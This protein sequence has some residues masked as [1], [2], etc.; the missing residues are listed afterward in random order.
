MPVLIP[1]KKIPQLTAYGINLLGTEMLEISVTN[2]SRRITARDFVLPLDSVLTVTPLGVVGSNSRQLTLGI[3]LVAV[4]GGP[5]STYQ[6]NATGAVAGPANPTGTVGLT[7]VNG[8]ALTYMR[9]DAAPPLSQAIVPSWT[10]THE[11]LNNVK[12]G[13][14]S[15]SGRQVGPTSARLQVEGTNNATSSMSIVRN[16]PSNDGGFLTLGK[17]RGVTPAGVTILVDND[18]YGQLSFAG[19]D[20]VDLISVGARIT[21]QVDGVPAVGS[22]PGRLVLLTTASGAVTPTERFR[23]ISN[24]AWGLGG[25]TYGNAG[26][27]IT[28]VGAGGPP[29]W[30]SKVANPTALVGLA[31]VNGVATTAIRS[32]GA[33]ALDQA[34][35]PTWT[36]QHIFSLSGATNAAILAS[37]AQPQVDW[38]ETDAAANNRRWRIEAQ[39]EQQ[40]FRTVNDANSAAVTWMAVDR[41]LNVVDS[42]ALTS[43]ALTWNGNPLLSTTT[44]FANPTGTVGLATVNGAAT[45]AMRSDAAPPLSQAIAPTWSA[46]HTFTAAAP[47][48]LLSSVSPAMRFNETD[49]A[50]DNRVWNVTTSGEQMLFQVVNDAISVSTAFITVDRTSTTVD[51][52]LLASTTS[53]SLSSS[54]VAVTAGAFLISGTSALCAFTETDAAANNQRWDFSVISEQLLGRIRSDDGATNT[55]FMIVDRTTTTVDSVAFPASGAGRF[56]VGTTTALDSARQAHILAATANAGLIVKVPDTVGNETICCWHATTAGDATF[57][58]FSTEASPRTTRGSI[59]YNRGGG[60]VAYNTT[61]DVRRKKNVKDSSEASSLIDAIKIRS[62]DWADS[63]IHLEHWLVAQELVDVVPH[64]VTRGDEDRDWAIDPSK[65]I[66]VAIKELQSIRRRLERAGI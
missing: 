10:G 43:T 27:V 19:A 30:Q 33:P 34:I 17:S 35:A 14:A 15:F 5:G 28:S 3:G 6:L 21:A 44:A 37:S 38:N 60:L 56:L 42:I 23:I 12:F 32:D 41:T 36:A 25:A 57:V 45:T 39:G 63:D 9:S 13:S 24:G 48:I 65:L 49:A 22:M 64:A 26:D 40:L 58:N 18:T 54:S 51:S 20:G 29:T 4:D 47:A 1:T 53:L 55:N 31:A 50:A 62:F 7:A 8:A 52:L 16:N 59:S 11:F 61:S 2:T 46:L 66:P